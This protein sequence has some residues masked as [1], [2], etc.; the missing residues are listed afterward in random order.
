MCVELKSS[1]VGAGYKA[2][3]GEMARKIVWLC[4]QNMF[5]RIKYPTPNWMKSFFVNNA[6]A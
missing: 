4:L 3:W 5:V 1:H 6:L 2:S